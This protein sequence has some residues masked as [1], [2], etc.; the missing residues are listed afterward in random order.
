[1]KRSGKKS[2]A[3]QRETK[4]TVGATPHIVSPDDRADAAAEGDVNLSPLRR[5]FETAYVHARTRALLDAF[6]DYYPRA[7]KES[8]LGRA[9]ANGRFRFV[10]QPA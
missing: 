4:A 3:S 1:M 5:A 6:V 2:E 8:N 7:V 9:R 10:A